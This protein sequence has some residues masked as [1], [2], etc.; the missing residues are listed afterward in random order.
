MPHVLVA[1]VVHPA[2]LDLLAR[3]P[4]VT[5]HHVAENG[6]R[7]FL[8]HLAEADALIVRTQPVDHE[9]LARAPRLRLVSRHGVG[10]D[11]V[12]TAALRARGIA[13]AVVGDVNSRSVAEHAMMLILACAKRLRM[14]DHAVRQPD[15]WN[16]RNGMEPVELAGRRLLILGYGRIGRHLARMAD[17]FG[18][19]VRAFSPSV[20]AAG[21]P[22]GPATPVGLDEGLAWADV[23]AVSAPK[24]AQPLLG[25]AELARLKPAAILVNTARGGVVDEAALVAALREGRLAAAGLDVFEDE[26]PAPDHPLL[27][28]DQVILTPHIGGVTAEAAE[29]MS[30]R[31]AQN[32][33]D[34]LDGRLDP[35]MV[36]P[37]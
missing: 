33:L 16:W 6:P 1:G 32:V 5:V 23:V 34:F 28:L 18:M 29:R 19:K 20:E 10:T 15:R 21:W 27:A 17:A 3:A 30:V 24:R 31:S 2:G 11:S 7:A 8:P 26:P 22:D 4:G 12:D 13:L 25:A 9:V 37:L 14:A 35:A 36:V